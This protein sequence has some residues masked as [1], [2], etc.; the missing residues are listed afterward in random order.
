MPSALRAGFISAPRNCERNPTKPI[1]DAD[2]RD[3]QHGYDRCAQ[4]AP[5]RGDRRVRRFIV[6]LQTHAMLAIL[7]ERK[8]RTFSGEVESGL[9]PYS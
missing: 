1:A 7:P 2:E 5:R 3:R 8:S 6:G 9:T 4:P